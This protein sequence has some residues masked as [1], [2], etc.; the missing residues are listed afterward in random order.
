MKAVTIVN[1][2]DLFQLQWDK[3][4][5]NGLSKCKSGKC[6]ALDGDLPLKQDMSSWLKDE[7]QNI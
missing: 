2:L 5:G 7:Y 1:K 3:G 4:D 6:K